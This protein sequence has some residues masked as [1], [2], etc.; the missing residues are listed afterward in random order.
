MT[1]HELTSSSDFGHVVIHVEWQR[2]TFPPNF[3]QM[4]LSKPEINFGFYVC[5]GAW[6]QY[7]I[8]FKYLCDWQTFVYESQL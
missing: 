5:H 3:V 7:Q 6:A 8:W 4:S 2:C 1:C